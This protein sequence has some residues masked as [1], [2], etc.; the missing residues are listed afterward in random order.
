M[1]STED[2]LDHHAKCFFEFDLDGI[3]LTMRRVRL[4]TCKNDSRA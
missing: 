2:V 3:R 1:R 4:N